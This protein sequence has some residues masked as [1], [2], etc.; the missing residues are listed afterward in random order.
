MVT[1]INNINIS[2]TSQDGN[3]HDD[4]HDNNYENSDVGAV[5]ANDID[6]L[7]KSV[8]DNEN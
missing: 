7:S 6:D 2:T 4:I 3:N 1:K 8:N 5:V